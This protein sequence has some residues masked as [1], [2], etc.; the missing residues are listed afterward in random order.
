MH[1]MDMYLI[2][3]EIINKSDYVRYGLRSVDNVIRE[4]NCKQFI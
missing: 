1:K 4:I 2:I 3:N